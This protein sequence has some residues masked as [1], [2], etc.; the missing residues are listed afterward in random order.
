MKKIG[1]IEGLRAIAVI[2]VI[3][4]H[5]KFGFPGGYVGVDVFFVISGFLITSLLMIEREDR[6]RVQLLHFYARRA[7]RLLPAATIT[8]IVTLLL[9]WWIFDALRAREIA[10]DGLFSGLFVSNIRFV[11]NDSDYFATEF[12]ASPFQ[13]FWSLS[14]EEQFY[15]VW[16]LLL[17]SLW[18]GAR[19]V[20]RR[21][22][23]AA[24]VIVGGSLLWSVF[25]IDSSPSWTFFMLPTRAWELAAGGLLAVVVPRMRGRMN[26]VRSIG[27]WIGFLV[28][29]ITMVTYSDNTTFPG[30]SAVPVVL[31]TSLIILAVDATRV[32]KTMLSWEPMQ[33]IGARSYSLYLWHW[34][35]LI[36]WERANPEPRWI[37]RLGVVTASVVIAALSYQLVEDPI[38]RRQFFVKHDIRSLGFGAGLVATS[39][40]VA[41]LMSA[42]LSLPTTDFVAPS[43]VVTTTTATA[44]TLPRNPLDEYNELVA[45][46]LQPLIDASGKSTLLPAN[47]IPSLDSARD[48]RAEVFGNGCTAG[49]GAIDNPECEFG[50]IA[51]NVSIT[52]F[53]DS[54]MAHWFPAFETAGQQNGWKITVLTKL[55]CPPAMV[56]VRMDDKRVHEKC[57]IWR[58]NS[59]DR[60]VASDADVVVM[61]SYSY[62]APGKDA[63]GIPLS[64]MATGLEKVAQAF[65]D[66][67]KKVVMFTDT[68]VPR[69]DV[70]DCIASHS[71][72]LNR[73]HFPRNN[74]TNSS[75]S[76][77][78]RETIEKVGGRYI[79]VVHL[80]CTEICPS[81]IGNAIVYFD[82]DHVTKTYAQ[83]L[84]PY[85]GFLMQDVLSLS[86]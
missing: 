74:V 63:G 2:A 34:P 17:I 81:V 79:D 22:L 1:E 82:D 39:S 51:S 41:L 9:S 26:T 84:A 72:Q 73:C 55:G 7:R 38:R 46:A 24:S 29:V 16:P 65:V 53:G 3:L 27:G 33:W 78:E 49:H 86:R 70:V 61:S 12:L 35:L 14:V 30:L 62:R 5:A 60:I 83:T 21:L 19:D 28:V 59:I 31:G 47:V 45:D 25:I 6:G 71:K 66:A 40:V 32:L 67:G 76:L 58:Q 64:T 50:D 57:N 56:S 48:D 15:V 75:R 54:H 68:P 43:A 11:T 4:Y 37:E 8:I 10:K 36:L 77:V 13:H 80:F 42:S 20:R 85:V 69:V 52:L 23:V 18:I 44:I